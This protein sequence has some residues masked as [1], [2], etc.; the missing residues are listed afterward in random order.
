VLAR[1][2]PAKARTGIEHY[3][4]AWE[5]AVA[6]F[7][8]GQVTTYVIL[9]MGEDPE[10]TIEGCRRAIE[11]G[12]YPFVVPLRPVAGSLMADWT[13]PDPASVEHVARRLT[14]FLRARGIGARTAKAGCSRCNACS[15]MAA[16][17]RSL[18]QIGPKPVAAARA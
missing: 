3:F 5:R 2:A 1:V 7:G 16:V 17:E 10:L 14:P 15:P 11:L 13:P 8:P 12:V 6:R 4:A 18:L 9:G